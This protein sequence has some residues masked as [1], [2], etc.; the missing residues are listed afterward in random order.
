[1]MKVQGELAER[2]H[3]DPSATRPCPPGR[4]AQTLVVIPPISRRLCVVSMVTMPRP[5]LDVYPGEEQWPSLDVLN[6]TVHNAQEPWM[7]Y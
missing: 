6:H 4:G 2:W 1:M 7:F 5:V 3:C